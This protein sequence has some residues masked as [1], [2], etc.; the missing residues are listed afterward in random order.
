MSIFICD[1]SRVNFLHFW[2]TKGSSKWWFKKFDNSGFNGRLVLLRRS[3]RTIGGLGV[4]FWDW[5][6]FSSHLRRWGRERRGRDGGRDVVRER[7]G[8]KE[9]ERGRGGC[10]A[11]HT[12]TCT[13]PLEDTQEK[14]M[15]MKVDCQVPYN[16]LSCSCPHLS[17]SLSLS[18]S[19]LPPPHP[20]SL[21][22]S[23]PNLSIR[24]SS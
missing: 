20:S 8:G 23:A 16:F 3:V 9:E 13:Y 10:L 24:L 2:F 22:H 21:P 14:H 11:V 19:L 12:C 1:I 5:Q 15:D 17:L 18:L 4:G 6:V 7:G